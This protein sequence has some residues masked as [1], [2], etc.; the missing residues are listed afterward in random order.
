LQLRAFT[1][2]RAGAYLPA[3]KA[4]EAYLKRK[5]DDAQMQQFK[6]QIVQELGKQA[7][8]YLPDALPKRKP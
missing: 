2:W 6:K 7:Q 1:E 3:L 4:A 5:P 8:P